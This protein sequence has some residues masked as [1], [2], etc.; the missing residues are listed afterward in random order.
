MSKRLYKDEQHKQIGGVCAGLAEY[1]NLDVSVIRV[2]FLLFFVLK[3]TGLL[4]YVI[5]WIVLPKNP[6]AATFTP[7]VDYMHTPNDG[8]PG[9]AANYGR[10]PSAGRYIAG[11]ALILTGLLFLLNQLNLIPDFDFDYFWPV[12]LIAAGMVFIFADR[13]ERPLINKNDPFNDNPSQL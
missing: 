4:V 6:Y 9:Y 5:L 7:G 11:M 8:E 13:Q 10:K 1:L 12:L 3:G 2:A